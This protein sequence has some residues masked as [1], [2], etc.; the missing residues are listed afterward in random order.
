MI[1]ELDRKIIWALNAN[2]RKSFREMAKELGEAR[3]EKE[4]EDIL[5]PPAPPVP[6]GKPGAEG[7]AVGTQGE[8]D[9]ETVKP[10][11]KENE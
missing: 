7:T 1:D 10:A 5:N 4:M 6:P 3:S 2:A 8:G 9:A 11:G